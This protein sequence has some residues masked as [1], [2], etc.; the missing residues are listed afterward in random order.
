VLERETCLVAYL[1]PI[2]FVRDASLIAPDIREKPR[3]G[4][5]IGFHRCKFGTNVAVVRVVPIC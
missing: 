1:L 3:I 2:Y 4:A 5:H